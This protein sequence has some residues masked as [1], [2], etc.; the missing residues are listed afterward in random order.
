[1]MMTK[2]TSGRG[3]TMRL[4][5]VLALAANAEAWLWTAVINVPLQCFRDPTKGTLPPLLCVRGHFPSR[6][7]EPNRKSAAALALLFNLLPCIIGCWPR[8]ACLDICSQCHLHPGRPLRYPS[9]IRVLPII[10][11]TSGFA[12][13]P[14][15]ARKLVSL[16]CGRNR[17]QPPWRRSSHPFRAGHSCG[18]QP[19]STSPSAFPGAALSRPSIPS[20]MQVRSR[21]AVRWSRFLPAVTTCTYRLG[22]PSPTPLVSI[23]VPGQARTR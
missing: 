10:S 12:S 1:M 5:L 18:S 6:K 8:L 16:H 20:E 22:G 2:G 9:F 15:M 19:P 17:R 3:L 23:S 14:K 7:A 4:L 13:P 11:I 21:V